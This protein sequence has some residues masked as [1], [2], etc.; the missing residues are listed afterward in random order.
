MKNPWA[1]KLQCKTR[2]NSAVKSFHWEGRR[3]ELCGALLSLE[4]VLTSVLAVT[5][6]T[7]AVLVALPFVFLVVRALVLGFSI[8]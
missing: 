1:Q 3:E 4:D 6:L 8:P 2:I 7:A 5:V